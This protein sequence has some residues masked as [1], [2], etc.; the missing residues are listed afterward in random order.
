MFHAG[1]SL[2]PGV[3]ACALAAALGLQLLRSVRWKAVADWRLQPCSIG[4]VA[5]CVGCINN[6]PF[7]ML[8]RFAPGAAWP[9]L[10]LDSPAGTA[11]DL[12]DLHDPSMIGHIAG[13]IFTAKPTHDAP[14]KAWL[15]Q[16]Q[17]AYLAESD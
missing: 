16:L 9:E 15:I 12:V 4:N 3:L 7:M 1:W 13:C 6:H 11:V 10:C 8:P 2:P 5:R 14:G 17:D